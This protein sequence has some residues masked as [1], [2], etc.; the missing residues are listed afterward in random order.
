MEVSQVALPAPSDIRLIITDMDGTLLDGAGRVPD[1]LWTL[2][3]R[4]REHGIVFSPAS[5]RQYATLAAVFARV[6]DGMV[7]IAENGAYVVR[8]GAELSSV[9]LGPVIAAHAV[10]AVRRLAR[11]GADV[12]AVVCGK[13]AAYVER[14][15]A[16]FLA[17]IARYYHEYRVVEDATEIDD[18]FVK[19]AVFT[20]GA[21]EEAVY[22][23]V[24]AACPDQQVVVSS[25]H[26]V[27][28]LDPLTDKG[29]AV[30]KLQAELG[31]GPDQTM[32]FGD[33][34]NDLAMLDLAT[35]S[36]ATANA[37]PE[38]LARARH[39]APANT[40][41]GVTRVLTELLDGR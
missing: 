18:E 2:L 35:W 26:W 28:V 6:D 27:D 8:D 31:I 41:N 23:A 5:G 19:V 11:E 38:V 34:L 14:S 29:V 39:R 3:P 17:E 16:P 20:F 33:Y 36:F 37:H 12:G 21:A 4:L 15:D 1:E 7:Y 30:R 40:D 10:E 22:P 9:T 24:R 13:R 25:E 32:I